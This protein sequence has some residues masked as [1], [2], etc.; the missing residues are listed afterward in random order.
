MDDVMEKV[1]TKTV[2]V[3]ISGRVQGV[4][5]RSWTMH[6]ARSMGLDGWV[7]NRTNQTVEAMFKGPADKVD[8]MLRQCWDGPMI[9]R[10]RDVQFA[11][12]KKDVEAGFARLPTA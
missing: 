12:V 10:V 2:H 11:Q 5:F 9:S 1:E 3:V 4:G 8:A 7:R 6:T